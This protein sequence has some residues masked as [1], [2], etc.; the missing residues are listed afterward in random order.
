MAVEHK[1]IADSDLHEPL[2]AVN[3]NIND[4]YFASGAGSGSWVHPNPHGGWRYTE[5][6]VQLLRYGSL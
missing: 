1:N 3:A 4:L 2:G 6:P 5:V